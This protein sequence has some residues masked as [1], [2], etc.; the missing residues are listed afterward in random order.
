VLLVATGGTY[1]EEALPPD[2]DGKPPR[3]TLDRELFG[4]PVDVR[5]GQRATANITPVRTPLRTGLTPALYGLPT[6]LDALINASRYLHAF[7]HEVH[8]TDVRETRRKS[9]GRSPGRP[10]PRK[11]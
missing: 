10:K 9:P 8:L 2:D 7:F 6:G 3:L 5:T 4:V 11:R 1:V